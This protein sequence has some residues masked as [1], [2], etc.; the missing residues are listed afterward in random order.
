MAS[1]WRFEWFFGGYSRIVGPFPCGF[2][3]WIACRG[4]RCALLLSVSIRIDVSLYWF[5]IRLRSVSLWC[6]V[7]GSGILYLLLFALLAF[8]FAI[9]FLPHIYSSVLVVVG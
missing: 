9:V 2:G 3:R 7:S 5:I 6:W 8:P 4:V 1:R